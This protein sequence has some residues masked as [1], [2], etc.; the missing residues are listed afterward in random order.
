MIT[1]TID[2]I[3]VAWILAAVPGLLLWVGNRVL[4]VR[5]LRAIRALGATNGRLIVARYGV[6]KANIMIF[7][8]SVFV[9]IGAIAMTRPTNQAVAAQ[10][11]WSRT[12]LAVA[13]LGA[14]VALAVLGYQWRSVERQITALARA[15]YE[16]R[17]T[18]Q[19]TRE[20]EQNG[21][22]VEQNGR[23]KWQH[24]HDPGVG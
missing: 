7:V 20:V 6:R 1:R 13:L 22:E 24:D 8:Q 11:D 2:L 17:D 9:L 4:A 16:Q 23:E 21:R 12:A 18:R 3:E 14:P 5:S 15:R 19:D 10:W